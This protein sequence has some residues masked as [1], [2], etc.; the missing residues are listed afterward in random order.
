MSEVD[1]TKDVQMSC[2]ERDMWE[3]FIPLF[4]NKDHVYGYTVRDG[5][6][7]ALVWHFTNFH[8]RNKPA[9]PKRVKGW[10]GIYQAMEGFHTCVKL[11]TWRKDLPVRC[12]E[13][14]I[15]CFEIDV[16]EGHGLEKENNA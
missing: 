1:W 2:Q 9:E 12:G 13:E 11:R 7:R 4:V 5:V 16:P 15:A 10:L 3:D 6:E 8:F 14:L